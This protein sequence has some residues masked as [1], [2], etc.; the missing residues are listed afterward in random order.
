MVVF[1]NVAPLKVDAGL[2]LA[3]KCI[4]DNLL[5]VIVGYLIGGDFSGN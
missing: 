1:C 4:V 5:A 3:V 2:I